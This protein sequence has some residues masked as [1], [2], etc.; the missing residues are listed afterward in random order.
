MYSLRE[1]A[2]FLINRVLVG[3]NMGNVTCSNQMVIVII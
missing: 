2:L 3:G 1:I